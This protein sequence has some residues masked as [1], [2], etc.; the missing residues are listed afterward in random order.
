MELFSRDRSSP[1]PG[2][3]DPGVVEPLVRVLKPICRHM[4]PCVLRGAE[5]LPPHNNYLL[6]AN[7][8]GM[9]SAE[10]WTLLVEWHERFGTARPV[11]GMAHPAAF[12]VPFLYPVLQGLGAVEATAQGASKARLANVPLLIFPGGDHE[13]MRPYWE[14]G[15]V[16]FAQRK[17]WIRLARKHGLTIVPMAIVGSHKTLPVLAR[18]RALAWLSGLR[19]LGAHRGP[20]PLLSLIA[21]LHTYRKLRARRAGRVASFL[22]ADL[23]WLSTTLIPWIPSAIECHILDPIE[24]AAFTDPS[25]DD[26]FYADVIARLQRVLDEHGEAPGPR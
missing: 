26:A 9:G 4:W 21:A 12:R 8:S 16:D 17:G 2:V 13:A 3:F 5:K 19:L 22:A 11:A 18:G 15:R 7:H 14:A 25:A 23:M 10:L 20:L 6:V 1:H 24:P